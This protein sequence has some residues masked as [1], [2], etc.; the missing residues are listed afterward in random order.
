MKLNCDVGESFASWSKG[1]DQ[2]IMPYLDMANIA[3]GFHAS[4]PDTMSQTVALAKAHNVSIGAHPGYA[5]LQG[6]GRRSI[7]HT[8][9]QIVH[10]TLY[11][12][13]A[14][15]GICRLHHT[16]VDYIK[17]HG[18]L[19]N[20]MMQDIGLYSAMLQAASILNLPLM[21]LATERSDYVQ[22]AKRANVT[23]IHEGFADRRYGANKQL[24][25]RSLSGAVLED[26][27]QVEYQAKAMLNKH[28]FKSID[29]QDIR[30]HADSICLHG[31]NA[32]A[33][34]FAKCLRSLIDGQQ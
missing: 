20:D 12:V 8:Q 5:D 24:A 11:Q 4:D 23:L 27:K 32:N 10:L 15:Q 2:L 16:Q 25:P 29:Q 14:L 22:L 9:Q 13:G 3:C 21:I 17:P 28:T 30:L 33:L 1:D 7:A 6:F 31:D 19:Y 18:A 26:V 34:V